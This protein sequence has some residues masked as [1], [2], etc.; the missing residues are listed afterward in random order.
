MS[1][2]AE[3]IYKCTN[4]YAPESEDGIMWNDPLINIT[5]PEGEKVLSGKDQHY[6]SVE[7]LVTDF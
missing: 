7:N 2:T 1:E 3:F 5:W 6:K 4:T